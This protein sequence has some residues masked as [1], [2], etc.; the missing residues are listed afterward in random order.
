MGERKSWLGKADALLFAI[1]A[2]L[3][4]GAVYEG[5]RHG[6]S[7]LGMLASSWIFSSGLLF[8]VAPLV[9]IVVILRWRASREEAELLRKYPPRKTREDEMT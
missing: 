9:I 7:L 2:L 3:V 8:V 6:R 4:L 1:G 5:L